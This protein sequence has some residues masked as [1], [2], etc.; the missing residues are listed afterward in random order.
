[1]M[2]ATTQAA[3]H[4]CSRRW[5]LT[6]DIAVPVSGKAGKACI[7]LSENPSSGISDIWQSEKNICKSS[8]S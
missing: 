1:M 3:V 2:P 6:S 5:R 7:T 8:S 4:K